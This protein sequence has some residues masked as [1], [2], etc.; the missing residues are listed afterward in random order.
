MWSTLFTGLPFSDNDSLAFRCESKPIREQGIVKTLTQFFLA[1]PASP[2]G[3]L[4]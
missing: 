4:C 2:Y 3:E 1:A